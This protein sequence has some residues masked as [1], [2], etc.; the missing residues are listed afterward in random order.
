MNVCPCYQPVTPHTTVSPYKLTKSK[1]YKI[2]QNI[3]D[4]K[5]KPSHN[6]SC[7][8]VNHLSLLYLTVSLTEIS[9]CYI[10]IIIFIYILTSTMINFLQKYLEYFTTKQIFG[11]NRKRN[12]LSKRRRPEASAASSWSFGLELELKM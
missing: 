6:W 1:Y 8:D 3:T 10:F 2:L 11:T 4:Y 5:H 7:I 9:W 12:F